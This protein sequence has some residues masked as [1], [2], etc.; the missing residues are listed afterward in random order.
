MIIEWG[1]LWG[2]LLGPYGDRKGTVGD[3]VILGKYPC[4]N[5]AHHFN[6]QAQRDHNN[7]PITMQRY[8]AKTTQHH[9]DNQY[10]KSRMQIL[11]M[12]IMMIILNN[13]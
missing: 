7:I 9:N 6:V 4:L 3:R 8:K 1:P 10:E 2:P 12:L 13:T 11:T 5:S